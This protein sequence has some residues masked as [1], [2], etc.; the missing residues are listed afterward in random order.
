MFAT[1]AICTW[2]RADLLQ[3]TLKQFQ[4]L[5][6]PSGVDWELIV[7]DNNSNDHTQSALKQFEE[8]SLPL[9]IL[10]ETKQGHSNARNCAIENAKGEWILWTD[11]DVLVEPDW[12]ANYVTAIRKH[13]G[14]DF[15]GG[16]IEP[17]FESSP[18]RW[19]KKHLANIEGAYA[20][21]RRDH[22]T[23]PLEEDEAIFGANMAFRTEVL[24]S[25][26]FD[27][28]LGLVKDSPMRGDETD[29]VDRLRDSGSQG[30]WVGKAMVK[31]FIPRQRM[32]TRYLRDFFFGYGQAQTRMTSMSS[33]RN[34][35]EVHVVPKLFGKPRWAI[36]AMVKSWM[37][38]TILSPWKNIAWLNHLKRSATC[39][40]IVKES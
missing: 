14:I 16:T 15:A 1:V 30:L 32:T 5:S 27:P 2:N 19:L 24:R 31:H 34:E 3:Q 8:T 23:R 7:V 11:D 9:R 4:R 10:F 18:P 37:A 29:L 33:S 26:P 35:S 28:A 22:A 39:A 25:N 6:V 38:A 13:S 40:G 36:K 17:W 20:I 21:I 12:L